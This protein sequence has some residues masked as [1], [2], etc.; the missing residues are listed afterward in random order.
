[1]EARPLDGL[2]LKAGELE[3]DP[4]TRS[5]LVEPVEHRVPDVA[6]DHHRPVAGCEHDA[7]ERGRGRLAVGAGDPDHRARTELEKEVDLARDPDTPR[8]GVVQELGIPRHTRACVHDV[9]PVEGAGLVAKPEVD[10]VR[11]LSERLAQLRGGLAVDQAHC[12]PG[13]R[14]VPGQR[15]PAARSAHDE[16]GQVTSRATPAAASAETSPAPQK[17]S[18]MRFSDQ[19]AWW[20]V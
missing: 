6:A 11:H 2:Q 19:P 10:A 9:H 15:D 8:A 1:M 14:Q 7:G 13:A 12:V 4:V 20:N 3:H 17:E 16:D 18:A 5:D